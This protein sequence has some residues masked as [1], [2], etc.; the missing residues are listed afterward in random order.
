MLQWTLRLQTL[1]A[2]LALVALAGA[3]A[4]GLALTVLR[5]NEAVGNVLHEV[6]RYRFQLTLLVAGTAMAGSLYFSEV[7]DYVPCTLCWYQ[8]IAMYPIAI[9]TAVAVVRRQ[10]VRPS[11]VALAALGLIVSTY[12]WLHEHWPSLD[13]GV[14]S[15]V[16]RCDAIWFEKFG[17]VTLAFM[18]GSGFAAILALMALPTS[19]L[20]VEQPSDGEMK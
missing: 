3:L 18:A 7:A 1:S 13:A 5:G 19:V 16:I 17:F 20:P 11:V 9:I 12:H 2:F 4:V 15:A 8:R 10:W 14:C 6:A